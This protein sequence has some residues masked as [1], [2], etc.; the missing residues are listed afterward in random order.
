M[1]TE[2][3]AHLLF[4]PAYSP[5]LNPIENAFARLKHLLRKLARRTKAEVL[6]AIGEILDRYTPEECANYLVSSEYA[7]V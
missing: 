5:D 2:A 7:S 4:L 3:G 6:H 1:S